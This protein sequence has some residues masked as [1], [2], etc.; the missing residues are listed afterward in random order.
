[1]VKFID[2]KNI[3]GKGNWG[4]KGFRN[5]FGSDEVKMITEKQRIYIEKLL[6]NDKVDENYRKDVEKA[7]EGEMTRREASKII[8]DLLEM[9][10]VKRE[11]IA[12]EKKESI[13]K[14]GDGENNAPED[15]GEV[16]EF[17]D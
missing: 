8:D 9:M 14:Y 6:R 12:S 7:L 16:E 10:T 4:N 2:K 1:M 11:T 3:Y 13:E 5:N 17:Q 15:T